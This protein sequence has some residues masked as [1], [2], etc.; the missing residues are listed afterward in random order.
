MTIKIKGPA[1]T[2]DNT[3]PEGVTDEQWANYLKV[4]AVVEKEHKE[5][6]KKESSE[7]GEQFAG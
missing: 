5:L 7:A 1:P 2:A 3:K 4:Q 6:V